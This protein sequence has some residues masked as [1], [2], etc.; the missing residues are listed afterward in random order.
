MDISVEFFNITVEST[1]L[2]EQFLKEDS[3]VHILTNF[4]SLFTELKDTNYCTIKYTNMTTWVNNFFFFS[5]LFPVIFS[6]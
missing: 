1:F 5:V 6:Y 3:H 4:V 2:V